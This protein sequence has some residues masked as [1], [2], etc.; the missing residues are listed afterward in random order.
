MCEVSIITPIFNSSTTIKETIL[1]VL[2]QTYT[3]WELILVDDCSTDESIRIIE[4]IIADDSRI[5]LIRRK[6]NAGA[7]VTRNRGIQ[8]AVGRYICFLDSDDLWERNKLAVQ[9]QFMK[10]NNYA[11]TYSSYRHINPDG[12]AIKTISAPNSVNYKQLLKTCS[13]GCLTAMY[14]SKLLGKVYMPNIRRRQDYGLWLEILKLTDSA[15]GIADVLASYRIGDKNSIS[16]NKYKAAIYQWRVYREIE[17]LSIISSL[18][19]MVYY[20][21]YGFFKHYIGR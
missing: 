1:S 10:S 11:L 15:Y 8:Q 6:W 21:F 18:K 13:I 3:D 16:S 17:K 9:V 19:Y 5:K 4:D 12:A 7:A 2:N 14:D 20:S